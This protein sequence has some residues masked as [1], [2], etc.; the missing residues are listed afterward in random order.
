MKTARKVSGEG[1]ILWE[2]AEKSLQQQPL[3]PEERGGLRSTVDCNTKP[4]PMEPLAPVQSR[5]EDAA[6]LT[7]VWQ[8]V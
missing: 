4:L 8:S 5:L 6:A 1:T 7:V 2:S 3:V